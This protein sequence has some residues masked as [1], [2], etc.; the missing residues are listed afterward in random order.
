MHVSRLWPIVY[1]AIAVLSAGVAPQNQAPAA[2]P[3]LPSE[4]RLPSVA[5]NDNRRP[6][7]ILDGDTLTLSLRAAA[8]LWRPE[9]E[10]GPALEIEAFGEDAAALTIPAPL[11][12]VQEGTEIAATV[13]NELTR[14]MRVFGLCER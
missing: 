2:W 13:R 6:A 7:G 4:Q 12:R 1:T 10:K 9:G 11:I 8:G 14:P 5:I 3:S